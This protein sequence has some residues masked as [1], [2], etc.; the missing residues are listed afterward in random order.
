[1]PVALRRRCPS[2][3]HKGPR[4]PL[5]PRPPPPK[6]LPPGQRFRSEIEKATADG[7]VISALMLKLTL[8]DAAKLRRDPS[9]ETEAISFSD[10]QMRLSGRE[11]GGGRHHR[12]HVADPHQREE[13]A[14]DD[15][16][17]ARS[18]ESHGQGQKKSNKEV[19]KPKAEKAKPI[20][21]AGKDFLTPPGK[22]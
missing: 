14:A 10:G 9:I 6:L 15:L 3:S 18:G 5:D 2:C 1:M 8:S 13:I 20:A 7:A 17:S 22:K 16:P 11:G 19:R 12:Q 4:C 21:T